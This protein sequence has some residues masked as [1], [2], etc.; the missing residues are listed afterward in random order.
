[1]RVAFFCKNISIYA[2]FNDQS[3]KDT[4]TIDIISFGPKMA[5]IVDLDETAHCEPSHLDLHCLQNNLSRSTG[6]KEFNVW[7]T[8]H[9]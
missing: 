3:F 5:N 1:M 8:C 9:I 7:F 2:I 6:S 4:L